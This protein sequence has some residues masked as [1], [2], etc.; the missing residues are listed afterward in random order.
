MDLITLGHAGN[1]KLE[2]FVR[3]EKST[4][5]TIGNYTIIKQRYKNNEFLYAKRRVDKQLKSEEPQLH[6]KQFDMLQSPFEYIGFYNIPTSS[7][8]DCSVKWLDDEEKGSYKTQCRIKNDIKAEIASY[9]LEN[10]DEYFSDLES[11][12]LDEAQ[13]HLILSNAQC[14]F[15]ESEK[16]DLKS[17]IHVGFTNAQYDNHYFDLDEVLE[18]IETP[19]KVISRYKKLMLDRCKYTLYQSYV[20][21]ECYTKGYEKIE[22]DKDNV[23]H[24]ERAIKFAIK[25]KVKCNLKCNEKVTVTIIKGS[26]PFTFE[27]KISAFYTYKYDF[28]VDYMTKSDYKKYIETF[29]HVDYSFDEVQTILYAGNKIYSKKENNQ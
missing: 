9:L 10:H 20:E 4:G 29:E 23:L 5:I 7:F 13:V 6:E 19:K 15:L 21:Y 28:K 2:A 1:K 11:P 8:Y 25:T 17:F 24:F 18:Y 26:I 22:N 3:D 12:E 14:D 27:T 16:R